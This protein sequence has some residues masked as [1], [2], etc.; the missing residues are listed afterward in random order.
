MRHYLL[1]SIVSMLLAVPVTTWGQ[2]AEPTSVD[3]IATLLGPQTLLVGRIDLDDTSVVKNM[4]QLQDELLGSGL[5]EGDTLPKMI[6]QAIDAIE[7]IRQAGAH[8]IVFSVEFVNAR[9]PALMA[10]TPLRDVTRR[11]EVGRAL[12][13]FVEI[14]YPNTS[15]LQ[16][17]QLEEMIVAGP[18]KGIKRLSLRVAEPAPKSQQRESLVA[19]MS[20]ID[21]AAVQ[22][23]IV[24]SAD[25]RRVLSETLPEFPSE[26]DG[27]SLGALWA[28]IQ[29]VAVGLELRDARSL[30][31]IAQANDAKGAAD[32][33]DE[34]K[35]L[36]DALGKNQALQKIVR[37]PPLGEILQLLEPTVQG[38]QIVMVIDDKESGLRQLSA[39]VLA[40]A[41]AASREA[42]RR[43]IM[44]NN[45]KHFG[46][47]FHNYHSASKE[48][49]FPDAAIRD[50]QGKPLLS[51]RV[52]VLP[53]LDGDG[54]KL[55][56]Q[57]HL[58]EPWDSPHNRQLIKKMP[59]VF[60]IPG[61]PSSEKGKTC[62]QVP[63]GA[64]T[65]FPD[66]RGISIKNILDGL[67]N[68]IMVVEV[69]EEHAVPWTQPSD[70]AYDP[71]H[72]TRGLGGHVT[73]VFMSGFADGSVQAI[74]EKADPETLRAY[75]TYQGKE[76]IR[77]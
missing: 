54:N 58:D 21:D 12:R 45:M 77:R 57:F 74:S 65:M 23:L 22:I 50:A 36:F 59:W 37:L 35:R 61:S 5:F 38:D 47:A 73:N 34:M 52:H 17:V 20:A 72:P 14:G 49:R 9:Q 32:A 33:V 60:A 8:E 27:G 26:L 51:W 29:W 66:G 1:A 43:T 15:D 30:K 63:V 44:M 42:S 40:P 46:I 71:E 6:G 67:S 76:T 75:F 4:K 24:P 2:P 28:D 31:V 64:D 62:F 7:V 55:Y 56:R 48:G 70:L 53:F 18:R 19:A 10:A 13:T 68:T 39:K 69:D 3:S 11:D 25:Q 16:D 41:I